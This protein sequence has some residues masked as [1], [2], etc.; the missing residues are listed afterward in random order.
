MRYIIILVCFTLS[1]NA[2]AYDW[3]QTGHRATGA[4]AENYLTN[5]AKKAIAELLDGQSLAFT[6]TYADEIKSDDAYRSYG[7]WHYV[8]VPFDSTYEK[9]EHNDRGDII[10]GID[11]C[12]EVIKSNNTSKEDKA[13]HLKLL[14]HFIG[15][16]HQPM[17]VGI[18]EDKGGNDFQVQ[19]Y[20][21][22]TNLH[23]VWDTRMIESY[24]MSYSELA[25]NMPELS[26]KERLAM[27]VGTHRDWMNDSR[28]I[29]KD[30]YANTAV[31]EKLG[32]RY[33]YDYFST[34]RN[35]LQKGG[36]RLAA[37]LNELL[38]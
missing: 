12:I 35:Q 19:W 37:L 4:I 26:K 22:G 7:P 20:N 36:V 17:H 31:G 32:Y 18:S 2:Q 14:V 8:N 25:D 1:F 21:D 34:V 38:G 27:A 33:M 28:V 16:L 6:S 24:G 15:D 29:V 30:I 11:K 5:K 3:G 23:S 10:Q 13:F 9:H